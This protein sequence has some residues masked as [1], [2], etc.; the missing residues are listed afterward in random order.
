MDAIDRRGAL[1]TL[2]CGAVAAGLGA[3]LLPGPAEAVPLAM[4]KDLDGKPD[5]F[6]HE[7]QAVVGRPPSRPSRHWRRHRRRRRVCWWHRGRR[8]CRWR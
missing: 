1:R 7:A 5:E 3:S 4:Q 6:R 2:L 8:V